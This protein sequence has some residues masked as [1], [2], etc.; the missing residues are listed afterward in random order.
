M[1]VAPV[2]VDWYNYVTKSTSPTFLQSLAKQKPAFYPSAVPMQQA[3]ES[4]EIAVDPYTVP[5]VR[6][7]IAKGAP[8]KFVVPSPAWAAPFYSFGVSWSK[9]ADAAKVF[10]D[11]MMSQAGQKA[12]GVDGASALSGVTG[13]LTSLSNVSVS[14]VGSLTPSEVATQTQQINSTFGR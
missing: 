1:N 13:T 12:L 11:F 3:V 14:K 4:G 2:F 10:L 7:D 5:S 6:S 9:H 8:L